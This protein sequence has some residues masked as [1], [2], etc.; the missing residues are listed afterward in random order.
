M[1]LYAAALCIFLLACTAN[2]TGQPAVQQPE[3]VEMKISSDAFDEGTMIPAKYTC[4]GDD[5]NPQLRIEGVPGAAKSL[6][7]IVDD[8]DAPSG[9]WVHWLVKDITTDTTEIEENSVPGVQ[10]VNDFGKEGY[11][12]PCPPSGVHRYFFRLYALDVENL[13]AETK[14]EFYEQV[15]S[16]KIDE[17]ELMGK[18]TKG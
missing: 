3:V 7:L 2:E 16:H 11:G 18:Y 4:Q 17:A 1:K 10:V 6:A 13:A 14:E 15:D 8:P 5:V 12:G 9:T